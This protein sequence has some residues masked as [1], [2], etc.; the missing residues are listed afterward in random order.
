M[1]ASAFAT[2]L[3][4]GLAGPAPGQDAGE[5][6]DAVA[7]P[8]RFPTEVFVD[9]AITDLIVEPRDELFVV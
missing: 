3:V 9:L 5:Q 8:P 1:L 6:G 7:R 4:L 2:Y